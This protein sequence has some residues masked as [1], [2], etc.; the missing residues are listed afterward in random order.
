M[1]I[2]VSFSPSSYFLDFLVLYSYKY[3]YLRPDNQFSLFLRDLSFFS[4]P[5]PECLWE[6]LTLRLFS[7][8]SVQK[9][10]TNFLSSVFVLPLSENSLAK[11]SSVSLGMFLSFS[12]AEIVCEL[13]KVLGENSVFTCV[14]VSLL[15][16]ESML[17]TLRS[18]PS[19]FSPLSCAALLM[20]VERFESLLFCRS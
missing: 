17:G 1:H 20:L 16:W 11:K 15:S 3:S 19:S 14:E 12:E 18:F 5:V 4:F 7:L 2:S 13:D 8:L 9:F 10:G 6:A